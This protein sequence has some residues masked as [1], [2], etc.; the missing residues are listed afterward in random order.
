MKKFLILTRF[1]GILFTVTCIIANIASA[2]VQDSLDRYS[3]FRSER[4]YNRA[5]CSLEASYLALNVADYI[6]T[7][8]ALQNY[9]V[10]EANPL[11][12]EITRD[13]VLFA[14]AKT[15]MTAGVLYTLRIVRDDRPGLAMAELIGL[16]LIY[17]GIVTHNVTV[18]IRLK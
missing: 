12:V 14:L 11:L 18:I 1:T 17:A 13:P 5:Y 2:Q 10:R 9:P 6:T 16:N 4:A 7:L 15:G 3:V 8:H